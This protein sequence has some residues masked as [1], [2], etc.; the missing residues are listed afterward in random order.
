MAEKLISVHNP[1][2]KAAFSL[3]E[4]KSRRASGLFLL[5]GARELSHALKAGFLVREV[6]VSDEHLSSEARDVL[7]LIARGLS[8]VDSP[9]GGAGATPTYEV[10]PSVFAKLAMREASDGIVAVLEQRAWT[11][12]TLPLKANPLLVAVQGIEKPGNLGALL[13][14]ADGAGADAVVVLDRPSDV[15]NPNTLRASLGAAFSVPVASAT[16]PEFIAFARERGLTVVAA[17]FTSAAV[18]HFRTELSSP[19]VL[20]LGEE[21]KGLTPNLID[22]A[23]VVVKIPMTGKVDSLN[24]AVAGSILLYEALRQRRT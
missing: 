18:D 23:D 17:A 19:C 12:K 7:A 11:L 16:S 3:R 14:S 21:A 22:A 10:S 5:E 24:L 13:R 4:S 6:F 2:V 1:K 8:S 15:F 9:R 20:L